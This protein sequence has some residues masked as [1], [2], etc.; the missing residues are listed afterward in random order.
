MKPREAVEEFQRHLE[1]RNYAPQSRDAYGRVLGRLTVF[2]EGRGVEA[3]AQVTKGMLMDFQQGEMERAGPSGEAVCV[4][5]AN[6]QL[7]MARRFF[8][9]LRAEGMLWSDPAREMTLVRLPQTLPRSILTAT[10]MRKILEQPD[11]AT[12]LG[13]RDRTMLEVLYSTGIRREELGNLKVVD[14]DTQSGFLRV[15]QGKG[16]KDR[17]VPLG[18]EACRCLENY[19]QAVR[20]QFLKKESNLPWLFVSWKGNKLSKVVAGWTVKKYVRQ[21][22]IIKRVSPHTFRH[23]CATLMLKN[24]ANIRH[25]QELLGHASLETTQIYTAVTVMDLKDVHKRCHPREKEVG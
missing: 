7:V 21:A 6:G 3:M 13:C 16:G 14:V 2:L 1:V 24:R 9:Y 19:L 5:T 25:V 12:V 22:G 8:R 17:V 10:E 23:T 20:P 11:T 18:K 15:N 4:R